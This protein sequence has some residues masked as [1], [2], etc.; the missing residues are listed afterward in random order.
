MHAWQRQMMIELPW[1]S[2]E[3]VAGNQHKM[4]LRWL[5]ADSSLQG[6]HD[7]VMN[8]VHSSDK[9]ELAVRGGQYT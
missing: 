1:Q 4:D 8:D 3:A 2:I 5:F 9:V 6:E 7:S